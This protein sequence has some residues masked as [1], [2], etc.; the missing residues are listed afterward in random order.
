M[1]RGSCGWKRL[2]HN[3]LGSSALIKTLR[4]FVKV[5]MSES[6]TR[7]SADVWRN[8]EDFKNSFTCLCY[9]LT[10]EFSYCLKRASIWRSKVHFSSLRELI[11]IK[12]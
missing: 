9:P 11:Y 1:R 4:I 10:A 6:V 7:D 5:L 2:V 8:L 12:V 3:F